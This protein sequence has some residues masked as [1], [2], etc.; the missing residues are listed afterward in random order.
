M[1][2]GVGLAFVVPYS[3]TPKRSNV[4]VTSLVPQTERRPWVY[5]LGSHLCV[6]LFTPVSSPE[7]THIGP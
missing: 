1:R 3:L 7:T 4:R 5:R 6:V 2:T